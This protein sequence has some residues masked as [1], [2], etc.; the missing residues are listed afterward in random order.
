MGVN[1][2][3]G[4]VLRIYG[5]GRRLDRERGKCIIVW[6]VLRGFKGRVFVLDVGNLEE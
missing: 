5:L 1:K 3:Y 4:L 2:I 6:Y